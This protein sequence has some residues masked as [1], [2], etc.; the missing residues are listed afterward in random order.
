[1]AV[2]A[3]PDLRV[4]EWRFLRTHHAPATIARG[5]AGGSLLF[6]ACY[7]GNRFSRSGLGSDEP[8]NGL[9]AQSESTTRTD[10]TSRSG[11]DAPD[12]GSGWTP[13]RVGRDGRGEGQR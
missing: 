8:S 13:G 2:L 4:P 1:M 12:A 6:D 3:V 5:D 9:A 11:G 7:A 10:A